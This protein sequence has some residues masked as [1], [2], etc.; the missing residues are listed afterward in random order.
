MKSSALHAV[1]VGNFTADA[2]SCVMTVSREEHDIRQT[3]ARTVYWRTIV[4]VAADCRKGRGA[5]HSVVPQ[6]EVPNLKYIYIVISISMKLT[7][8]L[9]NADFSSRSLAK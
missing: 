2:G 6:H 4:L 8:P 1:K 9:K 7:Y 5:K 3:S